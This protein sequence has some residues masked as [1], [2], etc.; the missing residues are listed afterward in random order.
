MANGNDGKTISGTDIEDVKRKNAASGLSYKEVMEVLA[1]TG[2]HGT[3][4][5]SNT[6]I[7]QVKNQI[8]SSPN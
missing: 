3:S 1:K 2:G 5:Y 4:V 8:H 6:N 7:E